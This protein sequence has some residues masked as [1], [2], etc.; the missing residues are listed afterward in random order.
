MARERESCREVGCL[1]K[2]KA[3]GRRKRKIIE[4]LNMGRPMPQFKKAH[5]IK[6]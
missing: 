5:Y 2:R 1:G 4:P 6:V 3:D